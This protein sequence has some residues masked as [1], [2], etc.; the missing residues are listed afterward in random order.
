MV[1][2]DFLTIHKAQGLELDYVIIHLENVKHRGAV[3]SALSRG[4]TPERTYVTGW[5][6]SKVKTD[7][8]AMIYLATARRASRS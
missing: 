1:H 3:Y 2:A 6:P 4:K 7:Q 8:R 5:D